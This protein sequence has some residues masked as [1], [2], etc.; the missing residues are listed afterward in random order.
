MKRREIYVKSL[1]ELNSEQL[2]REFLE[3][4]YPKWGSLCLLKYLGFRVLDAVFIH[5]QAPKSDVT[6]IVVNFSERLG[7]DRILIRSD[8]EKEEGKYLRGGNS[9]KVPHALDVISSILSAKRAVIIMQPTNRFTNRLALNLNMDCTGTFRIEV[10]GPGLDI[11]DLNRGLVSP[12]V[13]IVIRNVNWSVYDPPHPLLMDRQLTTTSIEELRQ[14]R[15][16]RIGQELL[17]AL[18]IRVKGSPTAFAEDWLR[19]NGFTEL[20]EE[21]RPVITFNQ[22]CKWYEDAFT[23]GLFYRRKVSWTNLVIS[24]S[25]LGDNKGL[26]YWDIVNPREKFQITGSLEI[27]CCTC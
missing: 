19:E 24:A 2:W 16:N 14:T 26:I 6:T 7:L 21:E 5:P 18:G 1:H 11:S 27:L 13:S 20:F 12:E 17:P 9:P 10:L 3:S 23:I 15:L 22:V 8:A 25:D 4:P